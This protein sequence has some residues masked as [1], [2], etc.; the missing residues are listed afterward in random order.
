MS[1]PNCKQRGRWCTV[2]HRPKV[3]VLIHNLV[4]T[5]RLSSFHGEPPVST[6]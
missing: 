5:A 4:A 3:A 2:P 6:S 1:R